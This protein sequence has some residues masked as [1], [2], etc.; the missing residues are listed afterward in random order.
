MKIRF[1]SILLALLLTAGGLN[2]AAQDPP[3]T[4]KDLAEFMAKVRAARPAPGRPDRWTEAS[5][6]SF[7]VGTHWQVVELESSS[8][9][10]GWW[11]SFDKNNL[12]K[13]WGRFHPIWKV[14]S[15]RTI[16]V[17]DAGNVTVS[18]EISD[19]GWFLRRVQAA[20]GYDFDLLFV[21]PQ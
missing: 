14:T 16:E 19:D 9:D 12:D 13:S 20:K 4:R 5:L 10:R 8:S 1:R 6:R 15:A 21:V 18:Y 3:D 17:T 2:S 7:L 11:M